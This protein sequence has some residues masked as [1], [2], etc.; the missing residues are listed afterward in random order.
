MYKSH[1]RMV[2]LNKMI[3]M[4]MT[5][6]HNEQIIFTLNALFLKFHPTMMHGLKLTRTPRP[7]LRIYKVPTKKTKVQK[8]RKG[9]QF[10]L[11]TCLKDF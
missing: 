3:I 10:V 7:I 5:Y 6:L 11:R 2:Y 4:Y 9:R 1:L 8:L